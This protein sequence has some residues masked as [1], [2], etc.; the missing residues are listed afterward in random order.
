MDMLTKLRERLNDCHAKAD[1]IAAAA[2]AENRDLN[3]DEIAS[4]KALTEEFKQLKAQIEA[5]SG[6]QDAGDTLG[7]S[8]GRVS[9]PQPIAPQDITP[10]DNVAAPRVPAQPRDPEAAA[11]SLYK[12]KYIFL[13][14]DALMTDDHRMRRC[15][16]AARGRCVRRSG[17]AGCPRPARR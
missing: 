10:S 1:A 13:S 8:A 2:E 12:R 17:P 9:Q 11:R 3:A 5:L 14:A 15:R 6:L 4:I 7:Q 16:A